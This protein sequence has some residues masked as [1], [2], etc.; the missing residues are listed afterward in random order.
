MARMPPN[1]A[2]GLL[3]EASQALD[4]GRL[5]LAD[6]LARE[7]AERFPENPRSHVIIGR[8]AEALHRPDVAR[9]AYGRA[10]EI[11]PSNPEARKCLKRVDE[12]AQPPARP[13]PGS[14]GYLVI[15]AWGAG[16]W[17]DVN[18]VLGQL[19]LAEATGR[20]PVIDWGA[21]SLYRDDGVENAWESFFEPLSRKRAADLAGLGHDYFPA[22]W[23]DGNIGEAEVHKWQGPGSRLGI[24][25]LDRRER[26]LVSDCNLR[27]FSLLPWLPP[28]H[29]L[30]GRDVEEVYRDLCA[31]YLCPRPDIAAQAD[32]FV[33]ERF[34]G[35]GVL[36]VHVRATDKIVE[37]PRLHRLNAQYFGLVDEHLARHPA[38]RIFLLTDGASTLAE[39]R[40]RYGDRLIATDSKRSDSQTGIHF[41]KHESR[42]RI[43]REVLLDVL[44]ATRCDHFIGLGNSSVSTFVMH[45]KAWPEGAC[46]MLGGVINHHTR[47][48]FLYRTGRTLGN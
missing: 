23:S 12:R 27:I 25:L 22:K 39:F 41:Q 38:S 15:K 17:S 9:E 18:H 16:F 46:R 31:R 33:S 37:D 44:I 26:V 36:G 47:N 34:G 3:L 4:Q 35:D 20:E 10:V 32:R 13:E 43:G 45:L 2:A 28:W 6:I 40:E 1:A 14:R 19:L 21:G 48:P 42:S 30:H 5:T 7:A 24:E 11:A 29:P 8:V